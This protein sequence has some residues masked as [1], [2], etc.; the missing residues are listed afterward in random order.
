MNSTENQGQESKMFLTKTAEKY[1]KTT[2]KWTKFYSIL[3]YIGVVVL[4][5]VGI[6][7]LLIAKIPSLQSLPEM[8]ANVG[9][10]NFFPFTLVGIAYSIMGLVMIIPA[11]YLYQFGQRYND[12]LVI[13]N[14]ATLEVAIGK[15]K[16]YWKFIGIYSII[17][18]VVAIVMVIL[19]IILKFGC[20][21]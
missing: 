5:I 4:I 11:T 8:D 21:V 14:V 6:L 10:S 18:I 16:S 2:A 13:N 17:A 7:S 19:S 15:M 12:A 3:C 9:M 20:M 1:L